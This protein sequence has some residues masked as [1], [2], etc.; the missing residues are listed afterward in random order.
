VKP[1]SPTLN[2]A[3]DAFFEYKDIR[4]A[5]TSIKAYEH[6]FHA[7]GALLG[8]ADV[9]TVDQ[10]D[11]Q[12]LRRAF[13]AYKKHGRNGKE[14]SDATVERAYST[15]RAFFDFLVLDGY[16]EGSIKGSPM[17]AVLRP[18]I[19]KRPPKPLDNWEEMVPSLLKQL[20]AGCRKGRNPW[21]ELD[22]A[23]FATLLAT[24]LR[25]S[26]FLSLNVGSFEG[27]RGA[28]LVRVVGKGSKRRTVPTEEEL[29]DVLGAYMSTRRE[30]YPLWK[31]KPKDPL[32][33]RIDPKPTGKTGGQ[34]MTTDHLAYLIKTGLKSAGFEDRRHPGTMA[35]ALRHTYA[36]S[37]A[38]AGVRV[39]VLRDLLGHSSVETTQGYIQVLARDQREGAAKNPF[40]V[41]MRKELT[42]ETDDNPGI[43]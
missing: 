5:P 12:R 6:D 18:K 31:P 26:E 25:A 7:I 27:Q 42:E 16:I 20:A 9:M 40:Y 17:A 13:S 10:I 21:P 39:D 8:D 14:R 2:Q 24:G 28:Q 33:I 35:H 15:W 19:I 3:I 43:A 38:A 1:R 32:F 11:G 41:A 37:L 29:D 23:V 34:R 22:V 30:H 4:L 36:T